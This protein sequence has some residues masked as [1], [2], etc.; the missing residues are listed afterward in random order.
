MASEDDKKSINKFGV[1][2]L[3]GIDMIFKTNSNLSISWNNGLNLGITEIIA[4]P[5]LSYTPS[6][7]F[8]TKLGIQFKL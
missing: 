4:L 6:I 7:T 5:E 1:S 8:M 2:L 3:S